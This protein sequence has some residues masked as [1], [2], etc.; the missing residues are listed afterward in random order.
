MAKKTLTITDFQETGMNPDIRG[1]SGASL[2]QHYETDIDKRLRPRLGLS[3]D[4]VST[5]HGT[6]SQVIA[7]IS[8]KAYALIRE[9]YGY[10]GITEGMFGLG[11]VGNDPDQPQIFKFSQSTRE[12]DGHSP[13]DF[14]NSTLIAPV[15]FPYKTFFYGLTAAGVWK[16]AQAA[17]STCSNYQSIAITNWAHP[18]WHSKDDKAYFFM[19]NIIYRLDNVTWDGAVLT[20]AD[21]EVIKTATE[22]GDYI[23]FV[24][25]DANANRSTAYLW[26]RD[27]GKETMTA[28]YDMGRGEVEHVA[29][30][31]GVP[32]FVSKFID[33]NQGKPNVD[34]RFI[35][36]RLNGSLVET[37]RQFDW[38]SL[39]IGD[40]VWVSENK[41]YFGLQ[42]QR[43]STD[44]AELLVASVDSR[45]RI[46]FDIAI[47]G[48]TTDL[49]KNLPNGILNDGDG[50]WVAQDAAEKAYSSTVLYGETSIFESLKMRADN[51]TAH[52]DFIGSVIDT[53][54][55][56]GTITLKFRKDE[57]T[58][59]ITLGT[60]NTSNELKN[61]VVKKGSTTEPGVGK[62]IQYRIEQ[63]GS[64]A[65]IV[66]FFAAMDEK[67]KEPFDI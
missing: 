21:S 4:T 17:S 33:V 14:E 25:Y 43:T 8:L 54:P 52:L 20:M 48:A 39:Q 46:Y 63:T 15:L 57:E 65:A 45:G 26:D 7:D 53:E 9:D 12:W 41:L 32:I 35:V 60:F 44:T 62:E 27:S 23:L 61:S 58:D 6:G 24:T 2:I 5:N 42:V 29:V 56:S 40:G 3:A 59:W 38:N 16:G 47:T 66:G 11:E 37:V 67:S 36:K 51:P 50:W 34:Y 18:I 19:N 10:S 49:T 55:L 30:L 13:F 28:K 22:Y 1:S 31:D 64:S